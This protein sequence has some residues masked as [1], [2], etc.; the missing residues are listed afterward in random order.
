MEKEIEKNGQPMIIRRMVSSLTLYEITDYDLDKL[1]KGSSATIQLN[2]AIGLLSCGVAFL[3]A[4]LTTEIKANKV[5]SAFVCA[6]LIGFIG[7]VFFLIIWKRQK[8]SVSKVIDE[9]KKREPIESKSNK[10]AIYDLAPFLR[11]IR[12]L[13]KEHRFLSVKWLR[14]K[15][16]GNNPEAQEALQICL[17]KGYLKTYRQKNPR[18]PNRPVLSCKLNRENNDLKKILDI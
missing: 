13:E 3:I 14:E 16:Y 2:F 10:S 9:I 4:L 5:F 18:H 12:D 8:S 6:T 17:D 15:K 11:R 7:G 1:A